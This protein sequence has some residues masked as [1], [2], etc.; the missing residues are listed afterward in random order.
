VADFHLLFNLVLAILFIGLLDPLAKLCTRFMPAPATRTE[1]GQPQY[2][3]QAALS[4]PSLALADAAREVLRIVD[5]VNAMLRK[6]LEALTSD[7]RKLLAEIADMDDTLDRLH[8]AVKLHLTAVSRE[9][10]LSEAEAKRCSDVL[11]FTI[12]LEHI[13][14]ILDKS[15]REIAAKKIKR[16]LTF[17]SEGL[18]DIAAMHKRVVDNLHLATSVFMNRDE[19][20]AR[21]LLAEKDKMRDVE[22]DATEKHLQ[23]L[24]EGRAESIETSALH[25]DIA[26]DLKRIMAHVASVAYPILEQRGALRPS[27]LREEDKGHRPTG[28]PGE[29]PAA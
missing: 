19:R 8:S 16:Q 25:I 23:R 15:L 13:G 3:N 2:I 18:H 14:D 7:D 27:R 6:F 22:R 24:R 26:R 28:S 21:A 1:P 9:E 5:I 29:K 10:G 4:T 12:N 20:S 11:T 17:S